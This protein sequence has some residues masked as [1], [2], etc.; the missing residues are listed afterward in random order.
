[1]QRMR[2]NS[3]LAGAA[4]VAILAASGTGSTLAQTA[5]ESVEANI[6]I[7]DV[8]PL[9]PPTLEDIRPPAAQPAAAAEE[10][11][12]SD[13]AAAEPEMTPLSDVAERAEAG[14]TEDQAATAETPAPATGDTAVI[15]RNPIES[16]APAAVAAPAEPEPADAPTIATQPLPTP[17]PNPDVASRPTPEQTGTVAADSAVVQADAGVANQLRNLG[18]DRLGRILG[19]QRDDRTSVQ[20]FYESRNFAPLWITD[21]KL[22]ERGRAAIGYLAEVDSHGLDPADYQVPEFKAGAGDAALAE[23]EVGLTGAILDYVRHARMGRVHFTRLRAEID[24]DLQRPVPADVLAALAGSTGDLAAALDGYQPQDPA[25][26]ALRAKLAEA[27]QASGNI[28]T[29]RLAHGNALRITKDQRGRTIIPR[30][31]RVPVLRARLNIEGDRDSKA[32]D[33]TV[34][35][36][37]KAFQKQQGLP[38]SGRL[39]KATV[40]AINGPNRARDIDVIIANLERW[41]WLPRDL[42]AKHVVVNIPD[43]TL[44]VFNDG[45]RI[46]K[47]KIVVGRPDRATPLISADMTYLTVN[48]TW[49][50]PPSIIR[51]EYLPALQRDPQALS[52]MGLRVERQSNGTVRVWQPPGDKNALGRIRFNFHN[53][54]LVFQHDT[55]DKHLFKNLRRANSAGCMRVEDPLKYGE[56]LLSMSQ[57]QENYSAKRLRSMYGNSSINIRFADVIKVHLTYQ[58]AF[59]DDS[60]K[61]VIRDDVYGH[62]KKMIA[63][64]KGSDRKVAETAV[65]RIRNTATIPARFEGNLPV[66]RGSAG[67]DDRGGRGGPNFFD[68]L[69]G[70][71]PRAQAP[72]QRPRSAQNRGTW[73]RVH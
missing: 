57:P 33:Q 4:A 22:N 64:M 34:A 24:Y 49:N 50:V 13:T 26:K 38:A 40:D 9:A 35:D 48:P 23:A 17:A 42:G 21:G 1:M 14:E 61:L 32:Y 10:A 25:Y 16:A 3:L 65:P 56:V 53:Q 47:T 29:P 31:D 39:T 18:A 66:S 27:R 71:G 73:H 43:Y 36:A 30:D 60:G 45:N 11:P 46:W 28:S 19:G 7:P 62:D 69:F 51:R 5:P 15:E 52:R 54:F 58:T 2:F 55:P 8:S 72:Q 63:I 59:V 37:V 41:R 70:G 6:P 44:S 12:A 20:A 67:R 68:R